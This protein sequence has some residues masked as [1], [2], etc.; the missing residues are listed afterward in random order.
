ML[1]G[2]TSRW[3]T[4]R[5]VG[6][7]EGVGHVGDEPG[8]LRRGRPAGGEQIGEGDAIDKVANQV[9]LTVLDPHFMDGDDGRVAELGGRAGLAEEPVQVG[10]AGPDVAPPGHLDGHHPVQLRILRLEHGPERPVADGFEEGEPADGRAGHIGEA[11]GRARVQVE[12]GPA[13]GA[14]DLGSGV[15][16]EQLDRVLA[17]GAQDVHGRL[18]VGA[19]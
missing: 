3:T 9:R 5:A 13:G 8:G 17:V 15:E 1:L 4:P 18:R 14:G 19:E 7:V 6:V 11:G 2:L 12:A 16:L 10:R